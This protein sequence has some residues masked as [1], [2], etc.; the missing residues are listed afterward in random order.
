M[1]VN[2]SVLQ[3]KKKK[4]LKDL[5]FKLQCAA[6][7]LSDIMQQIYQGK[8]NTENKLPFDAREVERINE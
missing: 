7:D 8:S 4:I 2:F 6:N 3:K 5:L 1:Y